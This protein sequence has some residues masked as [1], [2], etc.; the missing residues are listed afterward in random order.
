MSVQNAADSRQKVM[1]L[2]SSAA[3]CA[4][5]SGLKGKR[6]WGVAEGLSTLF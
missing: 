2:R 4:S 3:K 5:P 6:R 1:Y